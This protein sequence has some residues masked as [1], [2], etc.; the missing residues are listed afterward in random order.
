VIAPGGG[1]GM[2][3]AVYAEMGRDLSFQL[4]IV[5][6]SR[7][8]YDCYPET[9]QNGSPAP[10]LATFAQEV[11]SQGVLERTDALVC[12]SRGGQVVLPELWKA[13]GAA[14]P[15][16]VVINGGV[17]MDLPVATTWPKSAVTFLLVGGQD[18]FRGNFGP[19]E[20]VADL[21]SRVPP[22][23]NTT[24]ILYVHEMQHMPQGALLVAVL[25]LMLRAISTWNADRRQPP[26]EALRGI[27]RALN[28][29]GWSGH[30]QYTKAGGAWDDIEFSPYTVSRHP[31]MESVPQESKVSA[32]VELTKH[33]QVRELF[34]A[35]ATASKPGGGAPLPPDGSRFAAVANAAKAKAAK[36]NTLMLPVAATRRGSND[37]GRR[38]SGS[39]TPGG[40]SAVGSPVEAT[41]ISRALGIPR[42]RYASPTASSMSGRASFATCEGSPGAGL[43]FFEQP[44]QQPFAACA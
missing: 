39:L 25:P 12:G 27:L 44:M 18:Y 11:L 9:W 6:Q 16:A 29:S 37:C 1:T 2:N 31:V 34:L 17:A 14:V 28:T 13:M 36:A 7:A 4:E 40:R 43:F 35:A 19:Q 23:N 38:C 33:D 26:L 15:P 30:L 42:A 10:N 41:P 22:G 20:Y 24:A 5:G 32:P 8:P 21:R 3:G